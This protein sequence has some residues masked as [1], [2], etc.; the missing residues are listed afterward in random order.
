MSLDDL[1]SVLY[2]NRGLNT[3]KDIQEFLSPTHPQNIKPSDLGIS[4]KQ[5]SSAIAL[6]QKHIKKDHPIA[7]YGDYDVDGLTATAIVW[8]T[9]HAIYKNTFPHIPHRVTEGYGLSNAGID[10][11]LDQGA[12]LIITVDNGIV[13]FDQIAYAKSRDCDVLVVDHHEKLDPL[14]KADVFIHSTATS[15]AGLS[16]FLAQELRSLYKSDFSTPDSDLL[17]LV[18]ISVICDLVPL[19]GVNRSFAKYGLEQLNNTTRPG[20]KALFQLSGLSKKSSIGPYEVGFIIGPRLNASGRLAHALDSLRLL[21][22]TSVQ[23]GFDLAA[24]LESVNSD[25]QRLTEVSTQNAYSQVSSVDI[26]D[27]LISADASYNEG[28]IGL[29]AA[30]LVERFHRPSLAISIGTSKCKGSARSIPGFHI[31]DF[32]RQFSDI[33]DSVGGHAMAAGFTLPTENLDLFTQKATASASGFITPEML[34]KQHRIDARV[35]LSDLNLDLYS[36]LEEFAPFGLG[37]PR[38]V[39]A[40][41]NVSIFGLKRVGASQNHL[42]FQAESFPAIYFS[43]PAEIPADISK[44]DIIYSLDLNTFNGLSNLQLLIKNISYGSVSD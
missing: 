33:F 21:C 13:A 41:E 18:A 8:E 20:L 22:T 1:I 5:L 27:I 42:R 44:A 2:K 43:A 31:T 6:I 38:P 10:H 23:R 7:V 16:W 30:K 25:R 28:I 4:Q 37:N 32:L 29:I 34:V 14:P 24:T 15:A 35:K 19:L 26:P 12:K 9:L 40:S 36:K 39:F 3:P 17:S 11:C